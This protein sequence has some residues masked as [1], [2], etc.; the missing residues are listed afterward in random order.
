DFPMAFNL[1]ISPAFGI[2]TATIQDPSITDNKMIIFHL[3]R[4]AYDGIT[5]FQVTML[6][7]CK[8]DP[9]GHHTN[10]AEATKCQPI[11]SVT[12]KLVTLKKS[13]RKTRHEKLEKLAEKLDSPNKTTRKS[14]Q[15]YSDSAQEESSS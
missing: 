6:V 13:N 1:P 15:P 7:L 4:D 8:Y 14:K 12:R 2:F 10:I 9:K 3:K 11:I 5:T